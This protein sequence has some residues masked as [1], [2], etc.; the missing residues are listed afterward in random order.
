MK[1]NSPEEYAELL[2]SAGGGIGGALELLD[3]RAL[4][5]ILATRALV[6]DF[7][8][9]AI[10]QANKENALSLIPRFST[11]RDTLADELTLIYTALRDLIVTKKSE[12]APLCFYESR[13]TALELCEC[14]S[15]GRLVKLC[16]ALTIATDRI[17]RNAHVR[18]TLISLLSETD[19]I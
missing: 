12:G 5:P 10:S 19:M 17:A 13:D 4:S 8:A 18:M 1:T 3:S 11:K 7:V 16:E 15:I 2:V 9:L 14:V 6:K